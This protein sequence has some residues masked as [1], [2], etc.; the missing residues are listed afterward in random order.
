MRKR[1]FALVAFLAA[2]SA[3]PLLAGG[4]GEILP[5]SVEVTVPAESYISPEA[6]PGVQDILYLPLG[7]TA[8]DKMV[9]K[10]YRAVVRDEQQ[11]LVRTIEVADTRKPGFFESLLTSIG[12]KKKI[13]LEVPEFVVW[14][15]KDD[16]G[17]FVP[18]GRYSALIEA[19]DDKGNLGRTAPF[20]VTVD[21]TPPAVE[22]TLPYRIFSPNGDGN[23]D[24]LIVEQKGSVEDYWRGVLRDSRGTAVHEVTWEG[25]APRNFSW[26]GRDAL[27]ARLPDGRYLYEISAHDRA[28]NL[29]SARVEGLDLDT[30][31]TTAALTARP[32][33]VLAQ[34][35]RQ[36]G[37]RSPWASTCP[38]A[39]ASQAGASRS[40]TPRVVRAARGR[41]RSR[42]RRAS[43]L[44]AATT[45]GQPC[46]RAAT[47][48]ASQSSTSTAT[49]RPRPPPTP[50]ST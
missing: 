2:L 13:A 8:A 43:S 32:R 23:Q 20:H 31:V 27:G 48:R 38:C 28:G 25:S 37:R 46:P 21:N 45:P 49:T 12:L 3:G 18:Q 1:L 16:Q 33:L 17:G 36:Q 29:T 44:T 15:G 35:R 19:W 41:A 9:V 24:L 14:D 6:S 26:N 5:P 47:G 39:K 10:G 34:R 40:R 50:R 7:V 4:S 42:P 22:V 30:R 11:R